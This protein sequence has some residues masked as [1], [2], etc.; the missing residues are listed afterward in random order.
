MAT[1]TIRMSDGEA[2]LAKRFAAFEGKTFSEFARE[3]IME[4]IEDFLDVQELERAI[5]E[6]DGVRYTLDEVKGELGL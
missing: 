5:A 3:S 6:D 4:R 1:L 2:E